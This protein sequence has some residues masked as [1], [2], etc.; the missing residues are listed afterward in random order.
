LA[1][2]QE[3]LRHCLRAVKWVEPENLHLTLKFLGEVPQEQ[4][5]AV[6]E[7]LDRVARQHSPLEPEVSGLGAFP[8]SRRP[9]VVW[10][11]VTEG[12]EAL[13]R[14]ALHLNRELAHLGIA[15]EARPFAGHVTLGRIRQLQPAPLLER[16]MQACSGARFGRRP[17]SEF[18]LVQSLLRPAGPVYT[19]L[20]RFALQG[21]LPRP[22]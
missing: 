15:A 8:D 21:E 22:R 13:I 11:G 16:Q 10:A 5:P 20:R 4:I 2:I 19:I 17:V 3:A 1:G 9:R 18:C 7:A 12:R 14:L 6:Q